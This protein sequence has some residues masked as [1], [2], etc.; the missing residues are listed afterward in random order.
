MQ[1][2]LTFSDI[3]LWFA[4]MA[5]ILL[6]TSEMVLPYLEEKFLAIEKKPLRI[7]ALIFGSLFMFFVL[8]QIYRPPS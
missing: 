1:F 4:Y 6:I 2:P 3:G 7:S 8:M 5:I